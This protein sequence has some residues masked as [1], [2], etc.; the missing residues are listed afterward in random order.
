MLDPRFL[1]GQFLKDMV[2]YLNFVT[3]EGNLTKENHIGL[4]VVG[5]TADLFD[6]ASHM[7]HEDSELVVV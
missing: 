6:V 5:I 7:L 3:E 1:L 2:R 4:L